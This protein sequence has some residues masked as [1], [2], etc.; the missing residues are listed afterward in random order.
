MVD[1][2]VYRLRRWPDLPTTLRKASVY[3]ALSVMSQRPVNRGWLARQAG[4]EQA[5]IEEL[6]H[7]LA[8]QDAL[9]VLDTAEYGN[10]G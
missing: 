1:T 7:V 6:M 2:L 4:M 8:T 3:R 9:L 10:L 5:N